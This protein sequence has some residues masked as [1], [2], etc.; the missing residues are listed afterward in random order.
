VQ[1]PVTQPLENVKQGKN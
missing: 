1:P